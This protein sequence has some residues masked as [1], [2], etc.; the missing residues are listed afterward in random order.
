MCTVYQY[1]RDVVKLQI[2]MSGYVMFSLPL[3]NLLN[4]THQENRIVDGTQ[5]LLRAGV[6]ILQWKIFGW[7][8]SCLNFQAHF[9]E[10]PLQ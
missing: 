8:L 9:K 7:V 3:Q 1:P 6:I 10:S 2:R 5:F 4:V